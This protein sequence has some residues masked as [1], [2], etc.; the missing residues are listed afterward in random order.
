M[1]LILSI[2]LAV[3]GFS[4]LL[5]V[6]RS[7]SKRLRTQRF[8]YVLSDGTLD[9][10]AEL[11]AAGADPSATDDG[12][13][14]LMAAVSDPDMLRLLIDAG[15]NVHVRYGYWIDNQYEEDISLIEGI[16]AR[17]QESDEHDRRDFSLTWITGMEMLLAAGASPFVRM[18]HVPEEFSGLISSHASASTLEEITVVAPASPKAVRL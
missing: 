8:F 11:L 17:F 7:L 10:L 15:A 9:E 12:Y 3:V 2:A 14:A 18:K 4:A 6:F 16:C 1:N 13:P 5:Q